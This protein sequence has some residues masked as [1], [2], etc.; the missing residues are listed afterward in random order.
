MVLDENSNVIID[1]AAHLEALDFYAS[2]AKSA[3][4]GAAQVDWAAAQ[5]L[6]NQ[7]KIAMTRFWAHAYRQ[8]PKDSAVKGK[9]GAAPMIGGP[10]RHRRRSGRLVPLGAQG[11]QEQPRPRS[12]SPSPTT[13]TTW[14]S[15]PALG[16]V[17]R[18]SAFEKYQARRVRELPAAPRDPERRPRRSRGRP[19]RS[20]SRSWT[21][22]WCPML[23]KAVAGGDNAALLA[24]S[25]EADPGP[26][27][28]RLRGRHLP[29]R[30]RPRPQPA[31]EKTVRITDRRFALVLM[32]PAAL[33]LA[34]FVA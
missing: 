22:S 30:C 25:Q 20:G 29:N 24:D 33:F 9:I 32:A 11:N 10:R 27:Q 17:A 14:A 12:S 7:G 28:V 13:T 3:P 4:P 31:E 23:Q 15:N 5:N 34:V 19:Q 6:F 1:N 8:I 16:L 21:P 2:L 26:P 18:I